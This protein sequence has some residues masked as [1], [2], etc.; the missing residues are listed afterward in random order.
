MSIARAESTTDASSGSLRGASEKEKTR[1][2]DLSTASPQ[3]QGLLKG[4]GPAVRLRTGTVATQE[5]GI[6][7]K[8]TV[9][10]PGDKYEKEAERVADAVIR[11]SE[12]EPAATPDE[13]A[14]SGRLQRMCPRCRRRHLQGKPLDCEE[15]ETELQRKA[16]STQGGIFSGQAQQGLVKS[17][18]SSGEPLPESTR[19][20]FEPRIGRDLSD[21]RVHTGP[22]ADK[23]A[24][25]INA[26][27]FTRGTDLVFRRGRYDPDIG[28]G[29]KLLA[30][31]L[32]HVVQ[33]DKHGQRVQR[34]R[35]ASTP[36]PRSLTETLDPS[37]LSNKELRT[38]IRLIRRWLKRQTA[39]TA[40]SAE[41]RQTLA[42]LEGEVRR[43]SG[44]FD[45]DAGAGG[46]SSAD[47][48]GQ[49]LLPEAGESGGEGVRT[50]GSAGGLVSGY[51]AQVRVS[52][53]AEP[54]EEMAEDIFN[55][56]EAGEIDHRQARRMASMRRNELLDEARSRMS[57]GGRSF[58]SAIKE[59]GLSLDELE[60]KYARRVLEQD[61]ELRRQYGLPPL[62]EVDPESRRYRQAID[63]L[64][65]GRKVS[66]EIVKASGRTS[67]VVT[68]FARFNRVAGPVGTAVGGGMSAYE[69][70]TAPEDERLHVAG[71]EAAGFAGGTLG[72][73]AGGLV[74]GWAASLVCGPGAPVCAVVVS[75]VVVGGASYAGGVAGEEIY[76]SATS[77]EG[78]SDT[79]ID[80]PL[81]CFAPDTPVTVADGSEMSIEAV[82]PGTV[83]RAYDEDAETVRNC[84]VTRTHQHPPAP[85]LELTLEDGRTLKVTAGHP[86][87]GPGGWRPASE[88][89]PGEKLVVLAPGGT[90]TVLSRIEGI[91]PQSPGAGVFNLSV[92]DCHTYFAGGVLAHNK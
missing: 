10:E 36:E 32:T 88:V 37:S 65:P 19:A 28:A 87:R 26:E 50:G 43:R 78:S 45:D 60:E 84:E 4:G 85:L 64:K 75:V 2:D 30:H 40:L 80:T 6:Q 23:L 66:K 29:K 89:Q 51:D 68:G 70:A 17:L 14:P 39:T 83:V 53:Y 49:T 12:L 69:I 15:C 48:T 90:D 52:Q 38:E 3:T 79:G 44:E 9:N 13:E 42:D 57:P 18:P 86:L 58:S 22:T 61:P 35:N 71:R 34:E 76:E 74:G 16:T 46:A 63:D 1:H 24:R 47:H 59:E 92:T 91:R 82:T 20:F 56:M 5:P 77:G 8:L 7:A 33:Q 72:S 73:V 62:D 21:V 27:A 54:A 25:S 81:Y 11:M 31:E 55:R 67:R 41:L